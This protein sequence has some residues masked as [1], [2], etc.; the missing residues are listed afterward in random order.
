MSTPS[1]RA[2]SNGARVAHDLHATRYGTSIRP[3]ETCVLVEVDLRGPGRNALFSYLGSLTERDG[4]VLYRH[5]PARP[6]KGALR[7]AVG[8]PRAHT[9]Y[10]AEQVV[11]GLLDRIERSG[12][13]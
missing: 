3:E 10:E 11:A 13:A 2:R 9:P 8:V 6:R 4:M 12:Y 5:G 1:Q 7:V